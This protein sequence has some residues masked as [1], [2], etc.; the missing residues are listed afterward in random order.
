M[1]SSFTIS[2]GG[3]SH[4]IEMFTFP[5]GEVNV[6]IP[7][8]LVN[9]SSRI[10]RI[11]AEID[12]SDGVVGL[13]LLVDALKR[14]VLNRD[15]CVALRL[16]YVPY[17]R[18]DRVCN[19]GEPLSIKVFADLLNSCGFSDVCIMDPH[20]NV[21]PALIDNC[22][23]CDQ[24][25]IIKESSLIGDI[26]SGKLVPVA[27]D[28]GATAK[29]E[30]LGFDYIQ[31]NKVRDLATGKLSGFS[32]QGDVVGKNLIIIDDICDGGGTF[33]GLTKVL[34][35]AGA[36]SVDLYVTHG[37]FSKGREILHEGGIR[38]IYTK[39]TV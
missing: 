7:K 14:H 27:P 38:N 24:W 4:P 5:G 35:E 25:N 30:M 8:G 19:Q 39:E 12:D 31:G 29:V 13:L 16:D 26:K 17:A 10:Y 2:S 32:F 9:R 37:I 36:A 20:S 11:V 33:I 28:K 23:I 15:Y 1:M 34:L 3:E 6:R 21:T 22:S 18:Q